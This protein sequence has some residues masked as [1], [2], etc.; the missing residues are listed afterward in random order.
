M[1]QIKCP[2]FSHCRP[3]CLLSMSFCFYFSSLYLCLL[4]CLSGAGVTVS[5]P[6]ALATPISSTTSPSWCRSVEAQPPTTEAPPP[7]PCSAPWAPPPLATSRM[8]LV[9]SSWDAANRRPAFLGPRPLFARPSWGPIGRQGTAPKAGW[10]TLK[11]NSLPSWADEQPS[12]F[13]MGWT[14]GGGSWVAAH[15]S[16]LTVE[17]LEEFS[18]IVV[19]AWAELSETLVT[20]FGQNAWNIL[21]TD[22]YNNDNGDGTEDDTGVK[23]V[24]CLFKLLSGTCVFCH[25]LDTLCSIV[26]SVDFLFTVSFCLSLKS[27]DFIP[28]HYSWNSFYGLPLKDRCTSVFCQNHRIYI[29]LWFVSSCILIFF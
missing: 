5:V 20:K 8:M 11:G 14:G 3:V 18:G 13:R 6:A 29:I 25:T 27:L 16:I 10:V 4:I 26:F 12:N 2:S 15:G 7:Q 23:M 1:L 19:W 28:L 24:P 22:D 21:V 17:C 9:E